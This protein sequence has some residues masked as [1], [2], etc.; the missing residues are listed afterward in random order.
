MPK[1]TT[2]KYT[3]QS[4]LLFQLK[5]SELQSVFGSHLDLR[6]HLS[7]LLNRTITGDTFLVTHTYN[8]FLNMVDLLNEYLSSPAKTRYHVMLYARVS[9]DVIRPGITWH[10]T[11]GYHMVLY[12]QVCHVTLCAQVSCD[13]IRPG[14]T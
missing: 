12:T 6:A 10:Y 14:I 7:S 1:V 2:S 9:H 11:P 13:V 4:V 8:Y 3:S 5:V